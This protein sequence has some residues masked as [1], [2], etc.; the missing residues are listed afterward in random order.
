M[1][2]GS[3]QRELHIDASPEVVFDVVS[4]PEH[5]RQWWA[6]EAEFTAVPGEQGALTFIGGSGEKQV[7]HLTVVDAEPYRLFSFRWGHPEGATPVEGNSF[8]VTFELTPSGTGTLLRLTETG[9]REMGWEAAVLEETYNDHVG[10]WD[11]CMPRLK[12]YSNELGARR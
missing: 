3:I 2:F 1:E 12:E 10:G 6:D 4:S 11:A 9:F 7:A 8:L 5:V